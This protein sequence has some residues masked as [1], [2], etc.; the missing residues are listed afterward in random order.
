MRVV[1][2][3]FEFEWD[4]GNVGKNKRKHGAEDKEAEEPFFDDNR[5]IYKDILHSKTEERFIL[6]GKTKKG[7]LL[8]IVFTKRKDKIRVISARN[9]NKKEV[10]IYEKAA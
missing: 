5:I 2:E 1:K 6:I 9:I 7:K 10:K 8:Y 4:K 3:S